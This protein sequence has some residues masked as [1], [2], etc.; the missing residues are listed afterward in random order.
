MSPIILV[1][2][3]MG[4]AIVSVVGVRVLYRATGKGH[5]NGSADNKKWD[6]EEFTSKLSK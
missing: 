2:V 3:I 4:I 6:V 1:P 5:G